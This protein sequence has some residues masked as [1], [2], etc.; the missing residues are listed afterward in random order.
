[1]GGSGN[2]LGLCGWGGGCGDSTAKGL[3]THMNGWGGNG[4][5]LSGC[6][7]ISVWDGYEYKLAIQPPC[8]ACVHVFVSA[9]L[10]VCMCVHA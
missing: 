2:G 8:I 6:G 1:M 4:L 7:A 9:T 3:T 10:H 5:G